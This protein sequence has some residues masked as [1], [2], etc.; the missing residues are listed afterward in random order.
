M[1]VFVTATHYGN[2]ISQVLT[3]FVYNAAFAEE[4][5]LRLVFYPF[6]NIQNLYIRH[7]ARDMSSNQLY[8]DRMFEYLQKERQYGPFIRKP[9][10]F[11]LRRN[12]IFSYFDLD[13]SSIAPFLSK[14]LY[15]DQKTTWTI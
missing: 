9:L 5:E 4:K 7:Q 6:G 2:A 11:G 12:N 3:S 10:S 8:Y 13:F 14:R 15:L 1:G